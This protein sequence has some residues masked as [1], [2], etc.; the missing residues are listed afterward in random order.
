M[1]RISYDYKVYLIDRYYIEKLSTVTVL[2][3]VVKFATV[4]LSDASRP[5]NANIAYMF[6]PTLSTLQILLFVMLM[7]LIDHLFRT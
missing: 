2:V 5:A 1:L 6:L 3:E 4:P 7:L